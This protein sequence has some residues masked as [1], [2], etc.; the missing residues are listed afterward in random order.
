[1]PDGWTIKEL[2]K[3]HMSEPYNTLIANAFF[4][5]GDIEAWGRGIAMIRDA[6]RKN[7][8]D[9]PTFEFGPTSMMVEFKG[10]VPKPAKSSEKT[11][12]DVRERFGKGSGKSSGKI[13]DLLAQD[14][15]LTIPQLAEQI[16]ITPRAIEKN[17]Q[18]LQDSGLLKRVGGRKEGHWKVLCQ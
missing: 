6:C 8:T 4:R 5:T 7:G 13:L 12:V 2:L 18:K 17:I 3:E 10:E 14:G 1:M 11:R 15:E 9:F 16:G